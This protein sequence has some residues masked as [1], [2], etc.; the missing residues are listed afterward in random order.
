MTQSQGSVLFNLMKIKFHKNR[1]NSKVQHKLLSSLPLFQHFHCSGL[2][3]ANVPSV[4]QKKKQNFS[5]T[6][7]GH[8]CLKPF[9]QKQNFASPLQWKCWKRRRELSTLCCTFDFNKTSLNLLWA[10]KN[11]S[12]NRKNQ[13]KGQVKKGTKTI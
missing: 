1:M 5:F 7:E 4:S 8:V 12:E 3:Q 13:E 2:T 10:R 9:Q 11:N 6:D